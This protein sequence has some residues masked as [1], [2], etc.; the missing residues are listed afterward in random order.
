M[1]FNKSQLLIIGT[2]LSAILGFPNITK[3]FTEEVIK[4][5]MESP[6]QIMI[7]LVSIL[8]I[9]LVISSVYWLIKL[10]KNIE[11]TYNTKSKEA[12][13]NYILKL[14]LTGIVTLIVIILAKKIVPI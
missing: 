14:V 9:F 6:S 10:G 12:F 8:K 1:E 3:I 5:V 2:I 11:I 7:I 13:K 4:I